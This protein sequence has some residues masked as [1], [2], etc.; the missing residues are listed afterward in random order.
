MY[1][2]RERDGPA[3]TDVFVTAAFH[4]NRNISG[5]GME[6]LE[7]AG[8]G[9]AW[10]EVHSALGV[11]LSRKV[12]AGTLRGEQA[13]AAIAYL[14]RHAEPASDRA[15]RLVTLVRDRWRHLGIHISVERRWPD[16]A[17]GEPL[18]EAVGLTRQP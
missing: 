1:A 12:S 15:I 7:L 4:A 14:A 13:M 18:P 16:M 17:P 3:A 2:L 6:A 8:D 10:D 5:R 9:R 11:I